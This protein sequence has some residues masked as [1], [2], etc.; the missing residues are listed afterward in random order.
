M[1]RKEVLAREEGAAEKAD[2][3]P[4]KAR[5]IAVVEN[6][7]VTSVS[8]QVDEEKNKQFK[9]D[10]NVFEVRNTAVVIDC[11]LTQTLLGT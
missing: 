6:F 2:A 1:E 4:Q 9:F 8:R 11:S 3:L 7:M 10:E 5:K